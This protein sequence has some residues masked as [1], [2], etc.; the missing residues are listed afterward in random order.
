MNL[1]IPYIYLIFFFFT[2][3][4]NHQAKVFKFQLLN[5][6]QAIIEFLTL[7]L[8]AIYISLINEPT[9]IN[10]IFMLKIYLKITF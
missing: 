10:Q 2:L 5:I 1:S 8:I 3:D 6:F 4:K 9:L 7:G